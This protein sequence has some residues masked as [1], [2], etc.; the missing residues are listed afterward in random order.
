MLIKKLHIIS[1]GMLSDKH[2]SFGDGLNVI[3]G[4]NETGK[5]T[6]PEI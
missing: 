4:E 1:F 3:E 6:G 5:S 2:I